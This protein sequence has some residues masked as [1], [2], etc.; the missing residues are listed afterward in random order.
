[1]D[2]KRAAKIPKFDLADEIMA[3][4]RKIIAAKRKSP[5]EKST[6][7]NFKQPA[8]FPSIAVIS[9]VS[10][11]SQTQNI[12]EMI[13]ARDIEKLCKGYNLNRL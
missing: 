4:H 11:S 3:E 10:Q 1:M 13:V 7:V 2:T 8:E 9:S 6:A 5:G 12:V